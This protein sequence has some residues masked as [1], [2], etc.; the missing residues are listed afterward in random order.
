MSLGGCDQLK[1]RDYLRKVPEYLA[2]GW[3]RRQ[4]SKDGDL[5][6]F[7]YTDRCVYARKWD[8][9]TLPSRGLIIDNTTGEI[10]AR[11]FNK[12]FNHG[13]PGAAEIQ[14]PYRIFDKIDGSLIIA[15]KYRGKWRCS[16]RGSF[17]N[18]YIDY[19]QGILDRM[20]EDPTFPD[21]RTVAP[22]THMF[23]V[24]LPSGMD[25][26]PRAVQ[27]DA[28]LYYLG[29]RTT[30]NGSEGYFQDT[31]SV[32]SRYA[33]KGLVHIA[34]RQHKQSF[35]SI[36]RKAPTLTGSEGWV[37]HMIYTGGRVKVKTSWYL[38]LFRAISKLSEESIRSLIL[39]SGGWDCRFI[40]E[41]P[42]ELRDEAEAMTK[43]IMGR[44]AVALQDTMAQFREASKGKPSR[45]D[46]ALSIMANPN[47]DLLFYLFDGKFDIM[48]MALL[49][50][51]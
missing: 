29:S 5:S 35:E 38:A 36:M 19:A 3:I 44:Y 40:E 2:D 15:Y 22:Q 30:E 21:N 45:K 41:F 31:F 24:V 39:E 43:E 48:K 46:F 8:D 23:E 33:L 49:E 25:P 4:T 14:T 42:E 10:V 16:T 1:G 32:M 12:F 34:A 47:R 11:P 13:E 18:I 26:M 20:V 6:I 28:G 17:D 51:V 7:N 27:H 50:R 9:V 37:L